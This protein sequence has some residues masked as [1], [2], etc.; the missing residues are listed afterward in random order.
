MKA[1]AGEDARRQER[2]YAEDWEQAGQTGRTSVVYVW[3]Y[4]TL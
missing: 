1:L 4:L 3:R 2:R